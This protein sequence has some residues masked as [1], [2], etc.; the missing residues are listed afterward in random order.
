MHIFNDITRKFS[1]RNI[2]K[3]WRQ[4]YRLFP[5]KKEIMICVCCEIKMC[6]S[7]GGGG[8]KLTERVYILKNRNRSTNNQIK[9]TMS[10]IIKVCAK[11]GLLKK[12]LW[13]Q[14]GI[15]T[16]NTKNDR[17]YNGQKGNQSSNTKNE[18]QYNG[19]NVNQS[20]NT[21]ND[22]QY[23]GQKGT[24]SSNTKND[25]QYN[26]QKGNQ[27][28]NTKNDRQ[29]NGQKGNQTPNAKNYRQYNGQKGNQT[30]NTKNNRQYAGQ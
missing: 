10:P 23:N 21:K 20:S 4:N 5:S 14:K 18:W 9:N 27:T 11:T 16:P 30:P 22:R 13:Y 12:D 2:D 3:F 25:R 24:Q 7:R 29:Y 1:M 8:Y 17:Q 6:L 26:G 19:Q 15:Q 28:P